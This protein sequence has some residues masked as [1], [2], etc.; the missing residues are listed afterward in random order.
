MK[1]RIAKK[2]AKLY[3]DG[4]LLVATYKDRWNYTTDGDYAIADVAI[5]HP[6][7]ERYVLEEATRR[8][9]SG[10][11]MDNPIYINIG[12]FNSFGERID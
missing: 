3:L 2:K 6:K 4:K 7:V 12:F 10:C 8:G 5:L 1:K 11:W 9:W